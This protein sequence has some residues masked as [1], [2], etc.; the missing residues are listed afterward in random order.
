MGEQVRKM[1][2]LEKSTEILTGGSG[3]TLPKESGWRVPLSYLDIR[4]RAWKAVRFENIWFISLLTGIK[5]L[6]LSVSSMV[7]TCIS[8]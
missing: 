2:S 6:E 4:E 7:P 3:G 1:P 5:I 8:D